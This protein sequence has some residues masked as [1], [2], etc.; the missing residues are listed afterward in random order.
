M[1]ERLYS[2]CQNWRGV[3]AII[4]DAGVG[5]GRAILAYGVPLRMPKGDVDGDGD[6]DASDTGAISYATPG[7]VR[8]DIDLDGDVDV[9]D[10]N[11][12]LGNF[13]AS[14][15]R[16]VLSGD[17]DDSVGNTLGYA[18]YVWSEYV[19]R[20]H[21]RNRVYDPQS[22]RWSRRD[23]MGYV[24]GVNLY[25]CVE[26]RPLNW[27]DPTGLEPATI[28]PEAPEPTRHATP[29]GGD[30]G[31]GYF[32]CI[33]WKPKLLSPAGRSTKF[34]DRGDVLFGAPRGGNLYWRLDARASYGDTFFRLRSGFRV[35][36]GFNANLSEREWG[37]STSASLSA[38]THPFTPI[39]CDQN[40]NIKIDVEIPCPLQASCDNAG[41]V[42]SA[43]YP[44]YWEGFYVEHS[45]TVSWSTG[46][47][48]GYIDWS[49]QGYVLDLWYGG[50]EVVNETSEAFF[51]NW[52]CECQGMRWVAL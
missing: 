15:G 33:S 12:V 2:C 7:D 5:R 23:P 47:P 30:L 6:V 4:T 22:G 11:A 28:T 31:Y 16:G 48:T 32:T 18:G 19:S 46:G 3:V 50:V 39:K 1:E 36:G 49:V 34:E 27:V 29:D 25:L 21:V 41:T 20:N 14:L 42:S 17:K 26:D 43:Q 40:G 9:D 8:Q 24:D 45:V 52:K 35:S 37:G 13:G 10:F 44:R 51:G 38:R